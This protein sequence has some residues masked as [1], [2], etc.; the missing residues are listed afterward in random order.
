M[1]S[2]ALVTGGE[3]LLGHDLHQLEH[4]R[5]AG[6]PLGLQGPV[7]LAH[8]RGSALPEHPKD[9]GLRVGRSLGATHR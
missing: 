9:L 1:A 8:G 4:R 7:D 6:P 3:A 2:L 5:V